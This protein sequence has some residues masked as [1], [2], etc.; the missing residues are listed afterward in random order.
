MHDLD[1]T[2]TLPSV[3]RAP[4]PQPGGIGVQTLR[5]TRS[6]LPEEFDVPVGRPELQAR[7]PAL[8]AAS[9]RLD[10][11]GDERIAGFLRLAW[12]EWQVPAAVAAG[13][14]L[15]EQAS[16]LL[17]LGIGGSALGARALDR[18]LGP[19]SGRQDGPAAVGHHRIEVLDTIDPVRVRQVLG[20]LDP[21]KTAVA[22][23][24]KSGGTLET[25]AL[26]RIVLPWLQAA[27]ADEWRHRVILITDPEKG[28]LR[29]LAD[30]EGLAWLPV[31]P[32]VG[33]RFSVLTPV[34]ML[35]A[36]F[37]GLDVDAIRAG[38]EMMA[39]RVRVP[40]LETN[41]AWQLAAVHDAWYEAGC[42][43]SGLVAYCARLRTVGEW[44]QQLLGESLGKIRPDGTSVGWTPTF[45]E[46]PVDQH[47]QLQ[48][49]QE[50]P[51]DKLLMFLRVQAHGTDLALPGIEGPVGS[52]GDWLAGW[53]LSTVLEAE[54]AGTAAALIQAGRPV[55]ELTIDRVSEETIGGLIILF[56]TWIALAGLMMGVDPFDQPGVEAG[57]RFAG[58]LLGRPE[59]LEE[60]RQ[61]RELLG[62]D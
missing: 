60:G 41:P 53:T 57:K 39:D 20:G 30:A 42:R 15:R 35:P 3:A 18:S 40:D 47:S 36:A 11:L 17:V 44:F 45:A 59:Y 5:A 4:G 56:E 43:I 29:R 61:A 28:V 12:D 27:V 2:T 6:G 13:K 37:L 25:A 33:G 7:V 51:R 22:V 62:L 16:T 10:Q 26:F 50:G 21:A 54:R 32:D 38:A 14:A 48:L 8:L 24:S 46:G 19:D 31:A 9:R 58:G 23:I 55:I 52:I 34:G 1:E 49:W